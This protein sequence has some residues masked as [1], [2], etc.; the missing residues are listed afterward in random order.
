MEDEAESATAAGGA[1][2]MAPFPLPLPCGMIVDADDD[3]AAASPISC[4][5]LAVELEL[6]G[7]AGE[8]SV[9]SV[10]TAGGRCSDTGEST[11]RGASGCSSGEFASGAEEAD[12][13]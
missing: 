7:P 5:W 2:D 10:S 8:W 13:A 4:A 6:L 1:G 9:A 12:D 11:V 3:R